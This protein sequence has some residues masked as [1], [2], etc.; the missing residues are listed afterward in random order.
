MSNTI[1]PPVSSVTWSATGLPDGCVLGEH[2]GIITGTPTTA[3]D[4]TVS[5]T[6]ESNWGTAT[7]SLIIYVKDGPTRYVVQRDGSEL[8]R[9]SMA[10]LKQMVADRTLE[11]TFQI[12]DQLIIPWTDPDVGTKCECPMNFGTF[13]NFRLENDSLSYGLGLQAE[14]A[15]PITNGSHWGVE[16]DPAEPNNA[17][18]SRRGSGTNRWSLSYIRQWLNA[19]GQNWYSAQ[20][21][22]DADSA[23]AAY[24]R[25]NGFED[26]FPVDFL[27]VLTPV[28]NV[29]KTCS[30]DGGGLDV[31][32]DTFFLLST[33]EMFVNISNGALTDDTEGTYW[34]IWKKKSGLSNFHTN[35]S[36]EGLNGAYIPHHIKNPS[37]TTSIYLRNIY[38]DTTWSVWC[39]NSSGEFTTNS[40]SFGALVAPACAI[41]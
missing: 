9:I 18:A 26:G 17:D 3:G 12:G 27:E 33:H 22:A 13:K 11:E 19:K 16:F 23:K 20:H 2:T 30:Y 39:I 28:K 6:V 36:T 29:T 35:R 38:I 24:K 21:E 14:Y 15:M 8:T 25:T 41:C 37:S 1:Q 7:G 32:L 5:L 10:D 31:T 4:Y 34:E 40:P